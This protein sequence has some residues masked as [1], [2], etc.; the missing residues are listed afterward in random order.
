MNGID[1]LRDSYNTLNALISRLRSAL[2]IENDVAGG[3]KLERQIEDNEKE[4]ENIRKKIE[5]FEN[6]IASKVE[7]FI[8]FSF[9]DCAERVE[10]LTN[11]LR[12]IQVKVSHRP[13]DYDPHNGLPEEIK[14]SIVR[15]T[16]V[17]VCLTKEAEKTICPLQLE[18]S[19]SIL[20]GKS[21]IALSF[22]EGHKPVQIIKCPE[23]DFFD[24]NTGVKA[25]LDYLANG[26]VYY[27]IESYNQRDAELTYL[28]SVAR[29]YDVWRSMYTEMTLSGRF[30]EPKIKLKPNAIMLLE[31]TH[32]VSRK[33]IHSF[34]DSSS[35]KLIIKTFHE[36]VNI[37]RKYKRIAIVG[38]PGAGKTTTL[39]RLFY[40]LATSAAKSE[41][42]AL[43]VF[44]RLGAYSGGDF[45]NFIKASFNSFDLRNYLPNR[46]ILLLD[47]LN[48]MPINLVAQVDDWIKK[49]SNVSIIVSCR[50]L[51]YLERK[52]PL[53]RVD[54]AALDVKQIY[55]FI[56]N[57]FVEKD[58]CDLLFWSLAGKDVYEA[59]NWLQKERAD[60]SFD[61][62]WFGNIESARSYEVEKAKIKY[63]QD[64]LKQKGS[65]PGLLGLVS[66]PFLL[67][68]AIEIFSDTG[69]PPENKGELFNEFVDSLLERCGRAATKQNL[70]WIDENIQRQAMAKLAYQIQIERKGTS[71][72]E[73]WALAT[74]KKAIPT[75]DANALLYL[76]A[77]ARIIER[78]ELVRFTHQ[79]LQEYF[80]AYE[81]GEDMK[82]GVP[83]TKYWPNKSWW[84][85]TG[86]E[87]TALLL[88]GIEGDATEIVKWLTFVHPTL[89]YLSATESGVTC[90]DDVLQKLYEPEQGSRISPLARAE[91]GRKLCAIGDN[92]PGVGLSISRIPDIVWCEVPIGE[93]QMG[94]DRELDVLGIAWEGSIISLPYK[95]WIAKYPVTYTQFEAFLVDG[96]ENPKFWTE[97][98]WRWKGKQKEPR[99]WRDPVFHL[100]NHP[101]VGV[102][103]YEA[104]AFS[105]WLNDKL[106]ETNWSLLGLP[107]DWEIR[108]PMECEWEKAVRFPDGRRYPWGD[109]YLTGYA[110]I[111]ETF[112]D[113]VCG[114]YFLRRTTA[115]GMYPQGCSPCGALDMCGNIWEWCISR[116]KIIYE[117]PED[118][119]LEGTEH[120]GVRGGSW[121]NSKLFA[122]AAAHDCQ[123]ADLGVMD[124]GF[125]LVLAPAGSLSSVDN[126]IAKKKDGI[127]T[128]K[129]FIA[130]LS[131]SGKTEFI[132][133]VSDLPLVSVEKKIVSTDK[134]IP[135]DYGRV[136]INKNML[137]MYA[138]TG[139]V[140]YEFLWDSLHV[141][142][143]G[144]ILLID[145]TDKSSFSKVIAL[146]ELFQS[147]PNIPYLIVATKP[148]APAAANQDEILSML[149][150]NDRTR[151]VM[152][153]ARKKQNVRQVLTRMLSIIN[154]S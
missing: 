142:M 94:G 147:K 34:E 143:H 23:I 100:S 150:V 77:S 122:P 112:E 15:A 7:I 53:Y 124:V 93:F 54:I 40:D 31:R 20:K 128:L 32:E 118:V 131:G 132:K 141:E 126:S 133:T 125:R 120:R 148:D 6:L 72:S 138:P 102:T 140:E 5:I 8:S 59:W 29:Q 139:N 83:P 9:Q 71:V 116:W 49:N 84:E 14:Q 41:D 45:E 2:A 74:L 39:H 85:T 27:N 65:L 109:E 48:E 130:G 16:H 105:K 19:F 25:L 52:L 129:I 111:D 46:I 123:D 99:L 56:N 69:R 1:D 134:F 88:A 50:K 135:M 96:Y 81:M 24:W 103:W 3:F 113:A 95:F 42:Q 37:F 21:I 89:A 22:P 10:K 101:I 92:R 11:E 67:T 145:C 26:T 153:N 13:E 82:R 57:F 64:N 51:E 35:D 115:V 152:C 18:L 58:D 47:G 86:W 28:Q 97:S 33:I 38:D 43:P 119:T 75:H 66:N 80:A 36:L 151:L 44:A 114:P 4:R 78:G 73:E 127:S 70:T 137:Y 107:N 106:H 17:L 108:L 30:R 55:K 90:N 12:R 149:H 76:A 63:I 60:I 136:P 68:A 121:Y 104:Y 62:F 91:W 146:Y 79:L 61:D 154:P 144:L 110:N 117:F 87:E 98:G